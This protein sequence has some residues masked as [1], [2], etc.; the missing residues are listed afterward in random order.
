MSKNILDFGVAQEGKGLWPNDALDYGS[1][2]DGP[3]SRI[4]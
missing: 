2:E 3:L 1:M 4:E